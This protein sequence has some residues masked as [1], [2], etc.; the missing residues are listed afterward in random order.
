[1]PK[2]VAKKIDK[3]KLLHEEGATEGAKEQDDDPT[4]SDGDDVVEE[5]AV[6]YDKDEQSEE[7]EV[8]YDPVNFSLKLERGPAEGEFSELNIQSFQADV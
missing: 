6:N 4:F 7:D 3:E 1:M 8:S 5:L 2:S